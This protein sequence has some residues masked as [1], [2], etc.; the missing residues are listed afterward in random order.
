MNGSQTLKID[1]KNIFLEW[2]YYSTLDFQRHRPP[3]WKYWQNT[4]IFPSCK[5]KELELKQNEK[6]KAYLPALGSQ[7][8]GRPLWKELSHSTED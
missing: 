1:I 7:R 3:D 4:G 6:K 2:W 8:Q 5:I